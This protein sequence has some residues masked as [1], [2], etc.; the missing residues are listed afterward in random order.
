M[1]I[2]IYE[3]LQSMFSLFLEANTKKDYK[4]V[5]SCLFLL[6]YVMWTIRKQS[7][8]Y[9]ALSASESYFSLYDFLKSAENHEFEFH[10]NFSFCL[11]NSTIV[12]LSRNIILVSVCNDSI[13]RLECIRVLLR[14]TC[15]FKLESINKNIAFMCLAQIIQYDSS[16]RSLCVNTLNFTVRHSRIFDRGWN[17]TRPNRKLNVPAMTS[18]LWHRC[19]SRMASLTCVANQLRREIFGWNIVVSDHFQLSES[20]YFVNVF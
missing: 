17:W 6:F 8:E 10:F 3:V 13:E 14:K 19:W 20:R 4:L 2:Q 18:F 7:Y 15:T 11:K 1:H 9:Q 12:G 16:Y 5:I